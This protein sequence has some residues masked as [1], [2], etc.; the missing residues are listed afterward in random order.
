MSL[1]KE[2]GEEI[3]D[4]SLALKIQTIWKQLA[5]NVTDQVIS[6]LDVTT[7]KVTYAKHAK[8]IVIDAFIACKKVMSC[9]WRS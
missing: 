9:V 7:V 1:K 8:N 4:N 5:E 3:E 6:C 2:R